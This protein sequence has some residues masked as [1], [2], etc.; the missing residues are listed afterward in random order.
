MSSTEIN[1]NEFVKY[2]HEKFSE[3]IS[4]Q[5]VEDLLH[6][7]EGYNKD[8]TTSLGKSLIL[9]RL[10]FHGKKITGEEFTYDRE[11]FSGINV[12]IA[13]NH[14]G[15]STI[16]KIIKFALTGTDGI[17]PD[18]KRWI[19]EIALEFT[20]G[21][22]TYTC[23]ID[24]RGRDRGA[25]Y[26]FN[27]HDFLLLRKNHKLEYTDR[28]TEFSFKSTT[29]LKESIQ[30][31][32]FEQFSFYKLR[33]TQKSSGKEDLSLNTAELSWT[34][35]FKSIYLESSNYDFLFFESENFGAQG[36]KIFEMILGL[37]LTYPINMLTIKH[38][39]ISDEIAKLRLSD[40]ATLENVFTS[41]KKIEENFRNVSSQLTE[42]EK[43]I[44][45][46]FEDKALVEEY[47]TIKNTVNE[48]RKKLRIAEDA[49][50][51]ELA[52]KRP[53]EDEL[54]NL[55]DDSK[56]IEAEINR[57][58]KQ[59]L[60]VELYRQAE[61]FFTNLEIKVCPHCE[62]EVSKEKKDKELI[63]HTCS[64]CGEQPKEQKID[65]EEL[66]EKAERIKKEIQ[67]HN[68]RMVLVSQQIENIRKVEDEHR[69]SMKILSRKI[70]E[71]PS[72]KTDEGR[73][74][75]LENQIEKVNQDRKKQQALF[76]KK[77]QLV[78]DKAVLEFQLKQINKLSLIDNTER[79]AKLQLQ[80]E[81]ISYGL[82]ALGIRRIKL[83]ASILKILEELI[84]SEVNA[85]G[86][87][88][89]SKVDIDGKFNLIFTQNGVSVDF[90]DLEPGEK[91]RVKLGFYLSL[92]QL[93]IEHNL[94][95]HPRF[96]IF[97]SPGSEE[98]VPKHL[99]GLSDILKDV[100]NRFNDQLQIFVGSA[101][102][103]FEQITDPKK[104]S[105][106][107]EDEFIF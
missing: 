83:N 16:F 63:N 77:D 97:D 62:I 74:K 14:K 98:M 70:M 59:E 47:L 29:Q 100:N 2:V 17:K 64:L 52:R 39:K 11:L 12:W 107:K 30:N 24:R 66:N 44:N 21:Q 27:I 86:L 37:P 51:N 48:V 20:I 26:R 96:L 95:R 8:S 60:N 106:K 50:S 89:I 33:Y 13:D 58:S 49:Y 32:F 57:L 28:D 7:Q 87:T 72:T 103:E 104:T 5:E 80:K 79:L 94:G 1:F 84:L 3:E 61:S 92:I 76:D 82:S 56:K 88:S 22:I 23:F 19:E 41:K 69:E 101:L 99:Q 35:Y 31:F 36:K 40:K 6:L 105:V 75:V 42:A 34:T 93:D 18:I 46:N 71:V 73:L 102:R 43:I 4:F 65:E 53:I 25:L 38:D 81:I 10:I 55:L 54:K 9:N 45:V 68:S 78:R 90:R 85:F 15:K 91:L 67:G